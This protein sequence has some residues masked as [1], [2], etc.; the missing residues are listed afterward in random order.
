MSKNKE[1][2]HILMK[3]KI[4]NHNVRLAKDGAFNTLK[5]VLIS[6][7]N[8]TYVNKLKQGVCKISKSNLSELTIPQIRAI[9]YLQNN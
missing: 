3:I 5:W 2:S 1:D 6:T 7:E 9:S 8:A 4:H